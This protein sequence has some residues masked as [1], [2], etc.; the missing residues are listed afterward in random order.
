MAYSI[1]K[2]TIADM[3]WPEVEAAAARRAVMMVPVAVI[4]QHGPHLPLATDTYGAHLVCRLIREDLLSRGIETVIAPPYYL[5]MNS[6]TYTFPGSLNISRDTLMAALGECLRDYASWGFTTQFVLN[7]HG[8][9]PHNAAIIEVIRSLRA[10][11]IEAAY[12]MGGFIKD[13]IEE[14]YTSYFSQPLPKE[15]PAMLVAGESEETHRARQELTHQEWG[16]H[17]DERETSMIMKW[18]PETLSHP[19]MVAGLPPVIPGPDAFNAAVERDAWRELSPLGYFGDPA[20]AT[21]ENGD[22]YRYEAR[23]MAAAIAARVLQID[24]SGG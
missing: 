8:D 2:D 24:V 4:E 22:L 18:F 19:E 13:F 16:I 11:G 15:D 6:T 12:T 20:R 21:V 23:D 5:G 7:H 3:T 1:F 10:E 14:A 17:A 9:P